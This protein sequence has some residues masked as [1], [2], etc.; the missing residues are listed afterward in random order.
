[1]ASTL[2]IAFGS[3]TIFIIL[4][5][6]VLGLMTSS[7]YFFSSHC[8]DLSLPWLGLSLGILF[9]K[10]TVSLEYICVLASN[11]NFHM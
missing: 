3:K 10:P 1:M 2:E 9:L 11:F 4:T 7:V 5:L 8:G 6:P